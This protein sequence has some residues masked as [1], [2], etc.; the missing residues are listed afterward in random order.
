[1]AVGCVDKLRIFHVLNNQLRPYREIGIKKAHIVKFSNGG[2]LM[3]V[4]HPFLQD[5]ENDYIR[6]YN[7][8]T[9][10]EL[11]CYK[12]AHSVIKTIQWKHTDDFMITACKNGTV[13]EWKVSDWTI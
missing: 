4:A 5:N 11:F 6:V 12:D 13:I 1:M 8:L 3:S 10:E 9:L 7:A 2:H